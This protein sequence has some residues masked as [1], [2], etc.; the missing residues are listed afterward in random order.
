VRSPSP[1]LT[2]L[3]ERWTRAVNDRDVDTLL[4]LADPDIECQ[5]LKLTGD[6]AYSGHDGIARWIQD[7]ADQAPGVRTHIER[8][9]ALSDERVAAFGAVELSGTVVSPYAVVAIVREGK[10][11]NLRSYLSDESTMEQLGLL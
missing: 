5:P 8:V 6:G 4:E 1:D 10:I 9:V 7:R 2:D 3:I 11:T